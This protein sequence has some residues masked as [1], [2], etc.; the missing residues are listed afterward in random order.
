MQ[1]I[2]DRER[3]VRAILKGHGVVGNRHP[4]SPSYGADR[5]QE[6]AQRQYDPDKAKFHLNKSGV[7]SAELFCCSGDDRH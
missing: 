6:M 5:C 1:Y 3:I 4:I 7:S 2:Q